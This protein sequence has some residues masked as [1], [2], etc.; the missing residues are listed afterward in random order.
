MG[1]SMPVITFS[2][3]DGSVA[4]VPDLNPEVSVELG[5]HVGY[6]W[7]AGQGAGME[8]GIKYPM[9]KGKLIYDFKTTLPSSAG[10]SPSERGSLSFDKGQWA[11]TPSTVGL[12]GGQGLR[13]PMVPLQSDSEQTLVKVKRPSLSAGLPL[14]FQPQQP[15]PPHVIRVFNTSSW[16]PAKGYTWQDGT[17]DV[18]DGNP[19]ELKVQWR[20]GDPSMFPPHIHASTAEGFWEPDGGYEWTDDSRGRLSTIMAT[21]NGV[22]WTPGIPYL[23][24]PHVIADV[25]EG[26][27]SPTFGYTWVTDEPGDLR[28]RPVSTVMP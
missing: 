27:C 25:E 17:M 5:K 3:K 10:L 26:K 11:F 7:S 20:A 13:S 18:R 14:K 1:I 19:A 8:I 22:R 21:L 6:K 2:L 16:L 24:H 15:P 9:L 23:N 12:S 28:V 4:F